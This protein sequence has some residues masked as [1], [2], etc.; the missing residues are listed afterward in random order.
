MGI[1]S[2]SKGAGFIIGPGIAGLLSGYG[3]WAPGLAATFLTFINLLFALFFLPETLYKASSNGE[4][5]PGSIREFFS[6]MKK[7]ALDS[8]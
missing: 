1:V 4:S 3:Y 8:F 2:A 7:M 6:K 5:S